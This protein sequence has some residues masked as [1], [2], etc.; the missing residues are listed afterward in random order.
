[1]SLEAPPGPVAALQIVVFALGMEEVAVLLPGGEVPVVKRE[2]LSV[3]PRRRDSWQGES[4]ARDLRL[5]ERGD[6]AALWCKCSSVCSQH[7]CVFCS[8]CL[9]NSCLFFPSRCLNSPEISIR[10]PRTGIDEGTELPPRTA[11]LPRLQ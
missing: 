5:W 7:R 6:G 1:M 3:S 2:S 8:A 9:H 10:L 11:S 4:R